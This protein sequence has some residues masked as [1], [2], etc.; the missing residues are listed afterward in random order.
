M[1]LTPSQRARAARNARLIRQFN[2]NADEW[3]DILA[4]QGGVCPICLRSHNLKT[5]KPLLFNTDHDHGDG[6]TRGILCAWCNRKLSTFWTLE[7]AERVVEY[8]TNPPAAEA[9]GERRYGLK[10][11]VTNKRKRTTK[12]KRPTRKK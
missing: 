1:A 12:R 2:I 10:G 3:D 9:L 11:R 6:L 7:V 8:F 5:H 4:W